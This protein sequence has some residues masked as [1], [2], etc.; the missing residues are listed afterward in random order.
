MSLIILCMSMSMYVYIYECVC[1]CVCIVPAEVIKSIKQRDFMQY[2]PKPRDLLRN[3]LQGE[4]PALIPRY[5]GGYR[6]SS[7]HTTL[8]SSSAT[9]GASSVLPSTPT[10]AGGRSS[11]RMSPGGV[12]LSL[13]NGGLASPS[14]RSQGHPKFQRPFRKYRRMIIT[15]HR[16]GV[17]EFKFSQFNKTKFGVR[18]CVYVCTCVRVYVC[19]CVVVVVVVM[20]TCVRVVV[21]CCVYV[22]LLCFV[23]ESALDGSI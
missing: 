3:Q 8:A 18:V 19:T 23:S 12:S 22:L 4:L 5:L 20:C 14:P 7:K 13:S 10:S 2:A 15:S 16:F 21:M 11:S 17:E 9:S 6:R 1:V